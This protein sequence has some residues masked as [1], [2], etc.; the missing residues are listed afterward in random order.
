MRRLFPLFWLIAAAVVPGFSQQPFSKNY[1]TGEGLP[2]NYLYSVLQD[3]KG[4][5]WVTTDVGVSR[6]DGQ[7]FTSYNTSH[8]LPDNEIFSLCEDRKGRIWFATLNGKAGF[9]YNGIIYNENNTE[10]LRQCDVKGLIIRLF[11]QEDGRIAYCGVYKTILIDLERGAIEQRATESGVVVTWPNPGNEIGGAAHYFGRIGAGGFETLAKM[12]VLTQTIQAITIGDTLLISADRSIYFFERYTGRMLHVV[13]RL[14]EGNQYIFIKKI[15]QN[16]WAGTRNGAIRMDYP[17]L[18]KEKTYLKGRSVSGILEDREGGLWFSTFEEGLFYVPDPGIVHYGLED[19]LLHKRIIC[20]S[21]DVQ[22]H[23][24]IGLEG[25]A[26]AVFDGQKI[27]SNVIFHKNVTNKNIRNIRHF[28]DGST[29]VIGKAGTLVIRGKEKKLL[30]QRASDV[31]IDH[32]GVYWAGLNGIFEIPPTLVKHKTLRTD[33]PLDIADANP[34]YGIPRISRFRGFKVEKIEFDEQ[35]HT[36]I[37]THNGLFKIGPDGLEVKVL[38]YSIKDLEFDFQ[39]QKLWVLSES[40]GLFSIQQ[41]RPADSIAIRNQYGEVICRDL[42]RG[43]DGQYWVG[44]ASGL[45]CVQEAGG[46]L[47]LT[48]FWGVLGLGWD[49]INAVEVIDNQVFIGKDDGLLAIP[50]SILL[51]SPPS[52]LPLIKSVRINQQQQAVDVH[53]TVVMAYGQGSLSIEFEGLSYREPQY[54]RYRYRLSGLDSVWR[55]TANEA[56]EFASLRPG[57]YVFEVFTIN[58]AGEKSAFSASIRVQVLPPF[59]LR[60]WFFVL[61]GLVM[62]GGVFFYIKWRENR[63]R[64]GYERERQW[65]ESSREKAE[66]QRKNAD[67]KMLALRLQ[68]NPHFIFNVLNTI[69]GHYGQEKWVEA[70]AFIGKFARL[71]RFNLDYSNALIPLEREVELLRIYLELSQI[72]YPDKIRFQINIAPEINPMD[73]MIPSMLIQ[74][75]VENAVIHGLAPKSSA[76]DI[77]IDFQLYDNELLAEIRD[78]GVGRAAAA[79]LKLRDPHKPLATQITLE[80]LQLLRDNTR[81]SPALEILDLFENEQSAGTKVVLRIPI[82]FV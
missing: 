80:R 34:L 36:W 30:V 15:G 12:P 62:V 54:L 47:H 52:P 82:E 20:L 27:E 78:T 29:L 65:I 38:P 17:S 13:T 51:R 18:K 8:G 2:S 7:T 73:A 26:Y 44:T 23:L 32:Q 22:Q 37:G 63:L 59:W 5:I 35:H 68:M 71:L 11:E 60:G 4:Y 72:R 67:L 58:G 43:D 6:F 1:Q 21:R 64:S 81:T 61:T 70:N 49:K 74:P 19:G 48:N 46:Q 10:L 25:S 69:K 39:K 40:K 66:L 77:F 24:W 56:I 3:S 57:D 42:C 79:H 16:L 14:D 28:P 45:F 41:G 55:E 33:A 53:K 9:F 31:N 50:E 75:F 76:G